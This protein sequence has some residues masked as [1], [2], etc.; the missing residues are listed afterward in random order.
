MSIEL[1]RKKP[2]GATLTLA[3]FVLGVG[4]NHHHTTAPTNDTALVAYFADGCTNFHKLFCD[5]KLVIL[6][7]FAA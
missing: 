3:L 7:S 1:H 6:A 2:K 5:S 4:T